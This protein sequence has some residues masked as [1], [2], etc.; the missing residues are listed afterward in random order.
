MFRSTLAV[1][2]ASLL[3]V[4]CDDGGTSTTDTTASDAADVV[5]GDTASDA[6]QSDV[7]DGESYAC[8]ALLTCGLDAG[9]ASRGQGAC[10]GDAPDENGHCAPNC[11][12]YECG[13]GQTC[14]CDSYWCVDLPSGCDSCG[15]AT[16]PDASCQCD[17]SSGHVIFSCMGA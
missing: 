12:A 2:A 13:G 5:T 3:L 6:I 9:C 17:D 14:L 15:C 4:A 7:G 11:Y 1:L 10:I 16:A 8:G